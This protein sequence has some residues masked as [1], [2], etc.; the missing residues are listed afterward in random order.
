MITL[1]L[2]PC[3]PFSV[4]RELMQESARLAE[5]RD[6]RLHTHLAETEDETAYCQR[7]FGMR[8]LDYLEATGWLGD[9]TWLAHG[10]HF[11]DDE[12]ARLGAAGTG[13]ATAPRRTWCSAPACA[14]PWIW[15]PPVVRWDWP[16]TALLQRSLQSRR[17]NAPG[18][19]AWTA[20]L[21]AEPGDP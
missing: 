10:I 18:A 19:A 3:S 2:A 15:K 7:L 4:S 21:F 17:G 5:A 11:N 13:I 8:P 1:A 16:W 9:R 14:A 6:V 20:T 12:V